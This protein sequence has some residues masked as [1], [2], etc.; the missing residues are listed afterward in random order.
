M[1]SFFI[2]LAAFVLGESRHGLADQVISGT[3]VEGYFYH[4][5][6]M[7]HTEG[8]LEITYLLQGDTVTRTI[9]YDREFTY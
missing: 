3:E 6:E 2:V 7:K 1:K 5:G 4:D 9:V 8:Q